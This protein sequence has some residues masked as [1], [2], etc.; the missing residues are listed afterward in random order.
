M[1]ATN[2]DLDE[3]VQRGQFRNDLQSFCM[4]HEIASLRS[5]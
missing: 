5:Q 1:A 2:R 3:M 4:D